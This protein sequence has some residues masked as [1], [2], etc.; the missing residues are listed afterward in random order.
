MVAVQSSHRLASGARRLAG[1]LQGWAFLCW[2]LQPHLA[3]AQ[4]PP[5]TTTAE[6][7]QLAATHE[8]V[9]PV[10]S[11]RVLQLP[12]LSAGSPAPGRKVRVTAPEYDGTNVFHTLYLPPDWKS[13]W[14]ASGKRWPVIFE[15][16]GNQ[17]AA[18]A[19][20]GQPQDA[21]LG[22]G[23]SAGQFI[24]VSLPYVNATGDANETHWWG[25][26]QATIDYLKRNVPRVIKQFGGDS[27]AVI[28][29]G[30][31]R[32]AIGANFLGLA[33]D[34]VA[35]LWTAF[36]AH[37]HFDGVRQWNG[38]DW[39]TP[40]ADYQTAATKRL[41]RVAG[42]PYYVRTSKATQAFIEQRLADTTNFTYYDVN[43]QEIFGVIPNDIVIHSHNDRW[44][45][46]PSRYR[47]EAWQWINEALSPQRLSHK[48]NLIHPNADEATYSEK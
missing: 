3:T 12:K 36:V 16:T 2:A 7:I 30:F 27:E 29:C 39:G 33:D 8:V 34:E 31:S 40:L 22:Y 25:D 48:T 9:L 37:D 44:L 32:G 11:Q 18:C 14:Q 26:Q 21:S 23:L 15:L 17:W 45:L 43:M 42:R 46:K 35:K 4:A 41:Q 6:T 28:L 5:V 47:D 1:T 13:N 10:G 24:W 20:T 19:S 38:T